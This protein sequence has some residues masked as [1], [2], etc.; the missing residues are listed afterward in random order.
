M[1]E[2]PG[3]KIDTAVADHSTVAEQKGSVIREVLEETGL[4]ISALEIERTG[5]FSYTF[6][7]AG[8]SYERDVHLWRAQLTAGNHE[9]RIDRTLRADGGSEDKHANFFWVTQEEFRRLREQG[10]IAANSA[11]WRL[12]LGR[13]GPG[14]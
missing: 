1:L 13:P 14:E 5:G 11:A 4:D 8:I 3:G 2:F 6:E 10:K 7:V 9:V 12:T